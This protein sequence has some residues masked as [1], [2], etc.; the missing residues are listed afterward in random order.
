MILTRLTVFIFFGFDS[1]YSFYCND[2]SGEREREREIELQ[3]MDKTQCL[4]HRCYKPATRFRVYSLLRNTLTL[5]RLLR[6]T[7][8]D[9]CLVHRN[10]FIQSCYSDSLKSYYYQLPRLAILFV[11]K[12]HLLY[13]LFIIAHSIIVKTHLQNILFSIME[14]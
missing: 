11:A 4:W 7:P 6:Q 13:S 14:L 10:Y 8:R 9:K 12:N 1:W 3:K 5:H 2:N